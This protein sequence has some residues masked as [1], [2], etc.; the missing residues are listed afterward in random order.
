MIVKINKNTLLSTGQT[1][2]NAVLKTYNEIPKLSE[3]IIFAPFKVWNTQDN[4][5]AGRDSCHLHHTTEGKTVGEIWHNIPQEDIDQCIA[6][7][8]FGIVGQKYPDYIKAAV[9]EITGCN[10]SD[11]EIISLV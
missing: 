7:G 11:I 5:N 6:D 3:G 1:A 9:A 10:E 4:M 2:S 8:H